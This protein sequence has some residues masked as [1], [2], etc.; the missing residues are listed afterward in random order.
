MPERADASCSALDTNFKGGCE[1]S[2]KFT[3][4]EEI[5]YNKKNKSLHNDNS[6]GYV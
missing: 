3:K 5:V 4:Y 2:L 6:N 1:A